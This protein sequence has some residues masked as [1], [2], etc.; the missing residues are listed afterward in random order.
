[1]NCFI[2]ANDF[3]AHVSRESRFLC[4]GEFRNTT[5]S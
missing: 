5:P 3:S 2:I 1:M 4:T